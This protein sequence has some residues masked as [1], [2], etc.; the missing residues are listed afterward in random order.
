[1]NPKENQELKKKKL[2][3]RILDLGCLPPLAK[4]YLLF[5]E[6]GS[7]VSMQFSADKELRNL[8]FASLVYPFFL[9]EQLAHE[10][11]SSNSSCCGHSFGE[12]QVVRH[13]R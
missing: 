7:K 3:Q 6:L 1:M 8:F 5:K 4:G 10:S 11:K 13:T 12:G 2:W 9:E